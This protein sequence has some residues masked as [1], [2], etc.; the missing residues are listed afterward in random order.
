MS[1]WIQT[2]S[3]KAFHFNPNRVDKKEICLE[4]IAHALSYTCR[5]NGHCHA[6]YSVAEHALNIA[7][8]FLRTTAVDG[9]PTQEGLAL[10]DQALLHDAGEAYCGDMTAPLKR[11]FPEYKKYEEKVMS[12]ILRKY[13]KKVKLDPL[14]KSADQR[15][16]LN[17]KA[18]LFPAENQ[19]L[20]GIEAELAP[21]EGVVIHCFTP[22]DVYPV[23]LQILKER[24]GEYD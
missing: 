8:Y 19:L 15:I 23:Y 4:D 3:G 21:L 2:T 7:E 24:F 18:R 6:F 9:K 20:W 1:S 12:T 14:V 11:L 17:E 16:M 5:Y 13:L 22:P 10:A